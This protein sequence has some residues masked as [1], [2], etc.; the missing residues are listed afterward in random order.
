MTGAPHPHC[1]LQVVVV[2][3][4]RVPQLPQE[5]WEVSVICSP[6]EQPWPPQM[7]L[8]VCGEPQPHCAVQI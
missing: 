3:S 7:P 5:A 4:V 6:G 2:V 8:T 1:P